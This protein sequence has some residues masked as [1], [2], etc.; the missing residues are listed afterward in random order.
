[1]AHS[2]LVRLDLLMKEQSIIIERQKNEILRLGRL[3]SAATES[4]AREQ[5]KRIKLER[6]L[7][8]IKKALS[9]L[10]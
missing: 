3:L 9:D 2:E 4:A 8:Q 7:H 10:A 1:M 5:A 6:K